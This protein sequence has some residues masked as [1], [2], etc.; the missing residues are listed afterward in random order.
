MDRIRRLMNER[1]ISKADLCRES[2]VSY[3]QILNI[4]EGTNAPYS[5]TL[6]KL[7]RA[8]GCTVEHLQTG[9][10]EEEIQS[11]PEMVRETP[12]EWGSTPPETIVQAIEVIARQTGMKKEDVFDTYCELVKRKIR[13]KSDASA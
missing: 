6:S 9:K 5:Q 12:P 10:S 4:L 3:R 2:G 11:S 1:A 13:E 8:L 7:A